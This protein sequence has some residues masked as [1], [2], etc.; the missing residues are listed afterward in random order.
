[1]NLIMNLLQQLSYLT[2][3]VQDTQGMKPNGSTR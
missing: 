3:Q 2:K 1:M